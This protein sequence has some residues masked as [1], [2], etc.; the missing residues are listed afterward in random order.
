MM[1]HLNFSMS[2]WVDMSVVGPRPHLWA[3]NKTYSTK[4]KVYEA[5]LRK[6]RNYRDLQVSGFR[7]EIKRDQDMINRIKLDVLY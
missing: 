7:G 1:K 5:P 4:I 2:Y 6:T 3:Q